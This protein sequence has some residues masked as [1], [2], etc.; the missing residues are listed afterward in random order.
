MDN[1]E[2]NPL[3]HTKRAIIAIGLGVGVMISQLVYL[4][5]FKPEVSLV[6]GL[7]RV[8]GP[9][10]LGFTEMMRQSHLAEL[11]WREREMNRLNDRISDLRRRK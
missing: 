1:Q 5:I 9:A 10:L 2:P 4:A 11:A 3:K 6:E 7:V 8:L